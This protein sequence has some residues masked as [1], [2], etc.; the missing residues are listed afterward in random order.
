M[1]YSVLLALLLL[2]VGTITQW[3]PPREHPLLFLAYWAICAWVTLLAVLLALYDVLKVRATAQRSQRELAE[4]Q[5]GKK[6]D[7]ENP[8]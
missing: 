6:T 3:P 2:F 7:D 5:F 8:R 1:F 4:Q